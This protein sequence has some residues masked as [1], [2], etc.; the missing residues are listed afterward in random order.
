MY[1]ILIVGLKEW[2]AGKTTLARALLLRLR[3]KGINACGFKPRAG[4]NAWYDYD[5]VYESLS[6][7]RLYGKDAQLLKEA[8]GKNLTEETISPVHRLWTETPRFMSLSQLPH[9]IVDRVTLWKENP[10]SIVVQNATLLYEHEYEQLLEKLL[11]KATKTYR[12]THLQS[13]NKIVGENYD[14]AAE[15]AYRRI[16]GMH[17]TLIIEGY[18]DIA[19]PWR[20]LKEFDL[21]LGVEPGYITAYD[22][23]KYLTAVELSAQIRSEVRTGEVSKLLKSVKKIKVPPLTS[24]GLIQKMKEKV[25][26]IIEI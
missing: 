15:L 10:E 25:G 5:V 4:N 21:V 26:S 11:S 23:E 12:V 3:E 14:K 6:Q 7:G 22:A 17:D 9:F 20:G 1:R 19:L 13:L 16:I 8:S 18:S 24:D 2:G